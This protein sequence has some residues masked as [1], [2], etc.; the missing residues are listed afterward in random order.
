MNSLVNS[1]VTRLLYLSQT[2]EDLI[3]DTVLRSI[4]KFIEEFFAE[5]PE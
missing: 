2:N 5:K 4:A 1:I 3:I